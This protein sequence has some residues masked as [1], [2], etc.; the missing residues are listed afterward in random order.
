MNRRNFL[1]TL[2]ALPV[3]RYLPALPKVW[4]WRR[5]SA[6]VVVGGPTFE[7]IV[8]RSLAENAPVVVDT[9]ARQNA[10]YALLQKRV[11]VAEAQMVANLSEKLWSEGS[12]VDRTDTGH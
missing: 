1:K 4:R 12:D 3:A 11:A 10:L 6:S 8:T 9:V 5:M 7:E 2:A